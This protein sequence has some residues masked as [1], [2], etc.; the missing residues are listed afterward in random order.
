MKGMIARRLAMRLQKTRR[1]RQ[2]NGGGGRESFRAKRGGSPPPALPR[3]GRS[4]R[5]RESFMSHYE[6]TSL[7][8]TQ[9]K[10]AGAVVSVRRDQ[11]PQ[12]EPLTVEP[13]ALP[14]DTHRK[15]GT[16]RWVSW[17]A[18]RSASLG[19]FVHCPPSSSDARRGLPTGHHPESP[20]S[21]REQHDSDEG[22]DAQL[23]MEEPHR[24]ERPPPRQMAASRGW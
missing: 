21:E 24:E 22:D 9:V 8:S 15:A 1:A 14:G 23:H 18:L 16:L 3:G 6:C 20:Q 4:L 7:S 2:R 13:P 10:R 12:E 11:A 17:H 19:G 5:F